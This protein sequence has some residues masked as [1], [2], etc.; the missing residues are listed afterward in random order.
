MTFK[1][2][3]SPSNSVQQELDYVCH[4]L[5]ESAIVVT[6][7]LEGV[8][9]DVNDTFCQIS[10]YR[11]EELIGQ[12]HRV[13]NSNYHPKAFFHEMWQ[14]ISSG[15]V[16]RGEVKNKAKDGSFYWVNTTIVP[17][18]DKEG[19]PTQYTAIRFDITYRKRI[20]TEIKQLYDELE[21]RV[22]I[23]TAELEQA[24]QHLSE[25]L[26]RLNETEKQRERYVSAL[27]HDLRTPLIGQ[28]RAISILNNHSEPLAN[29]LKALLSSLEGS[30]DNLLDMV[31]KLLEMNHLESGQ[32]T[33]MPEQIVLQECIQ[34]V[35][36]QLQVV[37]D[38]KSIQVHLIHPHKVSTIWGDSKH[39]QRVVQNIIIN[40]IEHLPLQGKVTLSITEKETAFE[41]SIS[42]NGPGIASDILPYLFDQYFTMQQKTKK[43]GTGLGL[44]VCK[45]LMQLHQGSI[46]VDSVYGEGTTFI[47]TFPKEL[48]SG[49]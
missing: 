3:H 41:C 11:R 27:T 29:D 14:T 19:V 9:T 23:R 28:K 24:N 45:M 1:L 2:K 12:T 44:S 49:V 32:I 8:I 39:V 42:D 37:A 48:G 43:I 6:T 13:V 38:G 46:R 35:I 15:R 30:N 33:L 21:E 16:W 5:D 7:N 25:A 10:K 36:Q 26:M 18:L 40:A 47:L 34:S 4:A 31:N 17:F 22:K 20:E